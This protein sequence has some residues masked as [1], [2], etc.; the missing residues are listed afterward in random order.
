MTNPKIIDGI[1]PEMLT[2]LEASSNY[3]ILNL[4]SGK[5][6]ISSYN[7]KVFETVFTRNYF[8]RIDRSNLVNRAFISGITERE[9]GVYIHLK[10]NTEILIPRRRKTELLAQ[11]PICTSSTANAQ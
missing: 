3:T 1:K 8:V 6:L 4:A 11:Y 5:R 2:Y 10:N 7:L 9:D